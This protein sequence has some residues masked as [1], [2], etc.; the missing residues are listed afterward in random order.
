LALCSYKEPGELKIS[1]L[2]GKKDMVFEKPADGDSSDEEDFEQTSTRKGK[3]T[4]K[5]ARRTSAASVGSPA[6]RKNN[7]AVVPSAR[8]SIDGSESLFGAPVGVR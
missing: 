6:P 7:K 8:H 5:K 2:E 1:Q 4:A 3:G